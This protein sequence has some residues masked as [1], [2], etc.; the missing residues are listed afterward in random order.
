VGLIF[1]SIDNYI[2]CS[3]EVVQCLPKEGRV[4][5]Q[6]ATIL[7]ATALLPA[8][9]PDEHTAVLLGLL[10]ERFLSAYAY[11]DRL[12]SGDD[13]SWHVY[14]FDRDVIPEALRGGREGETSTSRPAHIQARTL[15]LTPRRYQELVR[16]IGKLI[17]EFAGDEGDQGEPCTVAFLAMDGVLQEGSRD[18]HYLSTFVPPGGVE[19]DPES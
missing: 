16:R 19:E 2:A 8:G 18:S 10:K 17:S 15:P 14:G 7:P 3:D 1:R 11:C 12:E 5:F 4:V 9:D 13:P 6:G